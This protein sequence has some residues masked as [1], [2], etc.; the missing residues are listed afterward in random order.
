MFK[1]LE[2]KKIYLVYIP[3][4]IYWISLFVATSVPAKSL[5]SVAIGDKIEHFAAFFVLSIMLT[6]ALLYQSKY[7]FLK[8]HFLAA[9]LVIAALYATIDEIHQYFIP[10]RYCEL[11]DWFADFTGSIIGILL[12]FYLLKKFGYVA[13]KE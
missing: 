9:S 4:S 12:I 5:P 3:L 6:L 13:G 7:G 8:K 1:Y 11:F 10:G 2:K